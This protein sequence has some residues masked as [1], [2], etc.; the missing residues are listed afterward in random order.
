MTAEQLP[1]QLSLPHPHNPSSASTLLLLN[2][3]LFHAPT[4]T[5]LTFYFSPSLPQCTPLN[6]CPLLS[7]IP[8]MFV[9]RQTGARSH[10]L[11]FHRPP[12]KIHFIPLLFLFPFHSSLCRMPPLLT[13]PSAAVPKRK[14][15]ALP[16]CP[17]FC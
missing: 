12:V 5:H 15:K 8:L 4:V 16:L 11:H 17:S 9:L 7:L 2:H 10:S 14:R 13:F 3:F 1:Q 6:A